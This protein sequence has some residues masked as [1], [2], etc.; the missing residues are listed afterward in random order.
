M[1]WPHNNY[2]L[3]LVSTLIL[4]VTLNLLCWAFLGLGAA[5]SVAGAKY[6]SGIPPSLDVALLGAGS[7]VG[8]EYL[9]YEAEMARSK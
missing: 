3:D 6:L 1:C 8:G 5:G 4:F 9:C 7:Y 2:T